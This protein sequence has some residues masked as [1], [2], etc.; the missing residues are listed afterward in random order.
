ME[1]WSKQFL[2]SNKKYPMG[3]LIAYNQ[4][5]SQYDCFRT[6]NYKDFEL[7]QSAT[8]LTFYK[9]IINTVD[10]YSCH[11]GTSSATATGNGV[12]TLNGGKTWKEITMPSTYLWQGLIYLDN[13]YYQFPLINTSSAGSPVVCYKTQDFVNWVAYTATTTSTYIN[14]AQLTIGEN[15]LVYDGNYFYAFTSYASD[16]TIMKCTILKSINLL[17]WTQVYTYQISNSGIQQ[18]NVCAVKIIMDNN[19]NAALKFAPTSSRYTGSTYYAYTTNSFA[20]VTLETTTTTTTGIP[21]LSEIDSTGVYLLQAGS[22]AFEKANIS[23]PDTRSSYPIGL[24]NANLQAKIYNQ[25]LDRFIIGTSTT[26][27]GVYTN[28][29]TLEFNIEDYFDIT[30]GTYNKISKVIG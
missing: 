5:T 4:I 10:S 22:Y 18:G 12:V 25:I 6:K 27:T 30:S 14:K 19:G 23:A 20:N 9:K 3:L 29:G 13:W 2:M 1:I 7:S 24:N 11:Y 8:N 16:S 26:T 28:T 17:E 15:N 21:Y